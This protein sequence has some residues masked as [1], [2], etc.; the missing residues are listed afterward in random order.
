MFG[1]GSNKEITQMIEQGAASRMSDKTFITRELQHWL[2]SSARGWMV[3]GQRYY[4]GAHDILDKERTAIGENGQIRIVE[5]LPNARIVDNQ[6]RKLVNQKSGYLLGTPFSVQCQDESYSAYLGAIFDDKFMRLMKDIARDS[7]NCGIAWLL[8]YY[9]KRGK[10]AFRR[11]PPQELL[12]FWTDADHTQLDAAVRI[13][14]VVS[15]EGTIRKIIHKVEVYEAT[16]ISYFEYDG[17]SLVACEPWHQDY[18]TVISDGEAQG[19]NWTKIP[20]V[21]FKCNSDEL[22]LLRRVKSLQDA[23]NLI[24]SNFSDTMQED[25]RNTIMVLVNYDGTDLGE[26]RQNLSTYGAVKVR[27]TDG[28][29]GDVKTLQ[30]AVNSENYQAIL[31]I[32]KKALIENGMGYDA[33]DD[34]LG[35]NANQMNIQSI[36][37]DID[38]DADDMDAEFRASMDEV[39]W[40]IDCHLAN[41]GLGDYTSVPAEIKFNRDMMMNS[42]E[43][44]DNCRNSVGLLS[45]RTILAHHP[46]VTDVEAEM[47]ALEEEKLKNMETFGLPSAGETSDGSGEDDDE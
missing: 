11:I 29:Q 10:L 31:Q 5:N 2:N 19:M 6:Y 7:L 42:G 41:T 4:I 45:T 32:M 23:I 34:R 3:A 22:P 27:S 46:F 30:V 25:I 12:P 15:Y 8:P 16:G 18:F 28:V 21:P 44:I 47:E 20:L 40:F 17:G 38:L 1:F 35:G 37:N 26:F 39:M 33:K 43:A 14:N 24:E 13:Y 36:Y 9:N